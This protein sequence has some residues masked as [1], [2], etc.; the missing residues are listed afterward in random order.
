MNSQPTNW[1]TKAPLSTT[2]KVHM[3]ELNHLINGGAQSMCDSK[4]CYFILTMLLHISDRRS[5]L[6]QGTVIETLSWP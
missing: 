6:W 1:T 2:T 5:K 4:G 3:E